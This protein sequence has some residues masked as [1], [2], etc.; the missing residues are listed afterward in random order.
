[1]SRAIYHYA[2]LVGFFG[3]FALLMAWP[4]VLAPATRLP[5]SLILLITV[6]PLLMP[7]R[8]LLKGHLKSCTWMSYI[9]L[10]YFTHGIVEAYANP[11]ERGYALIEV[12]F[13]LLLCF[14]AGFY[15]YSAEK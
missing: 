10:I 14:G 12:G 4:T 5:V 11:A 9:S 13:S 15:V 7:L 8:G 2:A 6:S 3:L 1:M